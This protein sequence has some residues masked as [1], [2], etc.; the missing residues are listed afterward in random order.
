MLQLIQI[1]TL[2]AA[3]SAGMV[4]A[5]SGAPQKPASGAKA[6]H[7][8]LPQAGARDDA[9]LLRVLAPANRRA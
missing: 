1:A 9:G 4:T 8:W 3:L 7:D 5:D 6:V 2:S